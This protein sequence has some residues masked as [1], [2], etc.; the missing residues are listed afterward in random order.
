MKIVSAAEAVKAIKSN[1]NVYIHSAAATPERLVDAMVERNTELLNVN[2]YHMHIEGKA[3]FSNPLYLNSF[4]DHPLFVSAN[5]RKAV[6][7]G[8]ADYIPIFYS[9]IPIVFRDRIIPLDVALMQVS[10]PD[11]HGNCSLGV[12][13]ES[14][15]AAMQSAKTVIAQ[16]NP[17]MPR[18]HG[19]GIVHISKIDYA[20]EVNDPIFEVMYGEPSE[21]EMQIGKNVASIIEDGATLQMGV[22]AI[23]NCVLSCLVNHKKLGVHTEMFSDGLMD[24]VEKG[25]ITGEFK[26]KHPGKIISSLIMGSKK[27][28]E[29]VDDNQQV[30][31]LDI[32]YVNDTAV[33]RQNPKVTAINGAIEVDMFGQICADSIGMLQYSG[34][35]GQMDFMRGAMLSEG[36]K[37]IIALPSVTSKGESK[38]VN[39]LKHG[40]SVVTTRAHARFIVT[41]YGIA[42]LFAKN[43]KQRAKS[44]ISIA[45]PMHREQ[46]IIEAQKVLGNISLECNATV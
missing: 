11:K 9:E 18:T 5:V 42:D 35:G 24:L 26:K 40:A 38:I 15:F 27:L 31:L 28:Y 33:I 17:N 4:K 44:L 7:S 23:P 43:L 46:L 12:S 13:V 45:H 21:L 37:P 22:G 20:V 32:G 39:F 36:G 41:E 16:I 10:L 19:D 30:A 8:L 1:D 14:S 34:V 3:A 29:F 2:L 25:V 6:Q